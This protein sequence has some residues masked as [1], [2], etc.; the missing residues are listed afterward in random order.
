MDT[1]VKFLNSTA[2]VRRVA[3][4]VLAG[5]RPLVWHTTRRDA[6]AG[7]LVLVLVLVLILVLVLVLADGGGDG[8]LHGHRHVQGLPA[9]P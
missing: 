8:P 5:C 2:A 3:A 1:V 4:R 6:W 9:R 7:A